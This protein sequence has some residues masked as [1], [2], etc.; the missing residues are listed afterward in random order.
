M[1]TTMTEL[2]LQNVDLRQKVDMYN[3]DLRSNKILNLE[4]ESQSQEF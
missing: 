3:S 1:E 2:R 4:R